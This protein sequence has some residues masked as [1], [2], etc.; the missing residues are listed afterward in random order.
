VTKAGVGYGDY[1][2]R[3]E[4]R[5]PRGTAYHLGTVD[6]AVLEHFNVPFVNSTLPG[7]LGARLLSDQVIRS[8]I[9]DLVVDPTYRG[10]GIG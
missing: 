5:S 3:H 10:R 2:L 7:T 6:S 4:K 8:V 9:Y 1:L